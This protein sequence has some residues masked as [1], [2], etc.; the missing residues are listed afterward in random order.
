[1]VAVERACRS[2]PLLDLRLLVLREQGAVQGE[3]GGP[4][5]GLE[6]EAGVDPHEEEAGHILLARALECV[7]QAGRNAI[8]H[9]YVGRTADHQQL[10]RLGE[11]VEHGQGLEPEA[12]HI[13]GAGLAGQGPVGH[14]A[15]AASVQGLPVEMSMMDCGPTRTSPGSG[16]S[17]GPSGPSSRA[18]SRSMY[19]RA[20][21][22]SSTSVAGSFSPARITYLPA[23][24]R[25]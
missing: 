10:R 19:Q 6:V 8:E 2:Q 5:R 11:V 21:R 17:P 14:G 3:I 9:E 16:E 18:I 4:G 20:L 24:P 1:R 15:H 22:R 13:E 23:A 25:L 12:V 7:Q